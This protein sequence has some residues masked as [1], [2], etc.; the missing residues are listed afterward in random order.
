[1]IKE[2]PI[3]SLWTGITDWILDRID[4]FPKKIRFSMSN[5]IANL[6]LE[7]LELIIDALYR[8]KKILILREINIKIQKL[9]VLLRICFNKKYLSAKQYEFIQAQLFEAGKMIG[10]WIKQRGQDG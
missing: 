9:R 8:R 5:R 3:F 1:M 2:A 4:D 6:T 10:G 7:V